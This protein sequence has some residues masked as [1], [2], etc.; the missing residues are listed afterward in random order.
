MH[1]FILL[2]TD[3]QTYVNSHWQVIEVITVVYKCLKYYFTC[4]K[5]PQL[6]FK[7]VFYVSTIVNIAS[8]K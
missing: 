6:R 5:F 3:I 2:T 1:K 8:R 7:N 4:N